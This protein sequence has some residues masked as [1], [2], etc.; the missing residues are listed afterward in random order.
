MTPLNLEE[1]ARE[2]CRKR[3]LVG[4]QSDILAAMEIGA[5]AMAA[6]C[7]EEIS[8]VTKDLIETRNKANAPQ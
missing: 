3:N 2:F 6:Q 1:T 7:S 5:S 4:Q 8:K